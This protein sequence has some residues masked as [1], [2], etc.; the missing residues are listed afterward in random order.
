MYIY[1]HI[2]H[3]WCIYI[4]W[5]YYTTFYNC[6]NSII[7]YQIII[8]NQSYS[9]QNVLYSISYIIYHIIIYISCFVERG[10]PPESH[11]FVVAF[12]LQ[13]F[14]NSPVLREWLTTLPC[15]ICLKIAFVLP[16]LQPRQLTAKVQKQNSELD[17]LREQLATARRHAASPGWVCW[18]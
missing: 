5:L 9:I 3:V 1:I 4:I 13:L 2:Y 16:L 15:W 17:E 6:L 12:I 18:V 8:S 11:R 7:L 14:S 10:N